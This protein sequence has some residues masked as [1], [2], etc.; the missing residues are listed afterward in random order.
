MST[1]NYLKLKA[2]KPIG[3][4]FFSASNSSV[5]Y[6]GRTA[7]DSFNLETFVSGLLP[8]RWGLD[9]ASSTPGKSQNTH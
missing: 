6:G 3:G 7:S 9:G 2:K 8:K 5:S 4:L 1:I